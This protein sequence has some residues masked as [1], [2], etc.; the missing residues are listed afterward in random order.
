MGE[1]EGFLFLDGQVFEFLKFRQFEW[2]EV[3]LVILAISALAGYFFMAHY[4]H[5]RT[6]ARQLWRKQQERLH[7]WLADWRLGDTELERLR[8][9]AGGDSDEALYRLLGDPFRFERA[10]D[11]AARAGRYPHFTERIRMALRYHSHNLRIPVVSTRQILTGDYFR[12]ELSTGGRGENVYGQLKATTPH[13]FMVELT[14]QDLASL[15]KESSPGMFYLRGHDVE[16]RIPCRITA[17]DPATG[18][19]T[20]A[21]AL[22]ETQ[23]GPRKARLPIIR[24]FNFSVEPAVEG[25]EGGYASMVSMRGVLMELS[26]GGFSCLQKNEVAPGSLVHIRLKRPNGEALPV[27]GRVLATQVHSAGRWLL[28]CEIRGLAPRQRNALSHLLW[29]EQSRRMQRLKQGQGKR[30]KG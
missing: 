3:L 21:H 19:L 29:S 23:H 6:M 20:V 2:V 1:R 16:H 9:L 13:G 22:V 25:G 18:L 27:T 17:R 15:G 11:E 28:R 8:Q 30:A 12:I 10:I 7:R 5:R 4:L 14:P 26:E 24:P